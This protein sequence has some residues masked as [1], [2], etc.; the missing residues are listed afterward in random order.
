MK[1]YHNKITPIYKIFGLDDIHLFLENEF[2]HVKHKKKTYK[3]LPK[4]ITKF[5]K[6]NNLITI[7]LKLVFDDGS[8][9]FNRLTE[10]QFNF[11]FIKINLL[12]D[13]D[14]IKKSEEE[15]NLLLNKNLYVNKKKIINWQKKFEHINDLISQL[16]TEYLSNEENIF[17]SNF[18]NIE[19][20][21]KDKNSRFIQK[22]KNELKTFFDNLESSPL[23]N[24][25]RVSIIMDDDANLVVAGAGTGKTSTVMGKI[26]YLIKRKIVKPTEILA[27][28]YGKDAAAEMRERVSEKSGEKI[29]IKTF[30]SFGLHLMQNELNQKVKISDVAQY[31]KSLLS[32]IA[33]I[34]SELTKDENKRKLVINFIAKH[35]Y[36]AKYLEDFKSDA[37]YFKYL[38]KFEPETLEGV[39]VKSFEELLIADWLTLNGISYE[40]ERPYEHQTASRLRN[41]YRPD[42]YIKFEDTEDSK[43]IYLE[44]FGVNRE[45]KTAEHINSELYN[46]GIQWKRQIHKNHQTILIE[47]FSW[48]RQEGILLE[49]LKHKLESH[50]IFC[51]PNDPKIVQKL[52]EQRNVNQKLVALIKDFLNVFKE[53]Q[54]T[55]KELE[56]YSNTLSSNEK[57]RCNCFLELFFEVF[58][59]YTNYLKR[60]QEIDFADLIVFATNAIKLKKVKLNFKRIIVDE[61]QDISRGRFRMIKSIVEQSEDCRVMCVGDDWQSIYGFTGSDI[62]MTLEFENLIG[63]FTRT[64]LDQTFRFPDPILNVSS[65]FIQKNPFQLLKKIKA[66]PSKIKKTIEIFPLEQNQLKNFNYEEVFKIIDKDR[67]KNKTWDVLM[68]GRYNFT[69]PEVPKVI[70]EKYKKLNIKFMTIHKSKGLGADAVIVLDL[71][72]GRMG[73]PGY[74]E[75][76]PLMNM[77]IAGEKEF[78]HS[79]ERRVFYVAMTRAKKKLILC[80]SKYNSSEFIDELITGNYPEIDCSKLLDI[81]SFY[82]PSCNGGEIELKYPNRINGY[83]WRCSLHPYCKGKFKFCKICKNSPIN[84]SG[85][86]MN[87][88]CN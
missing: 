57:E 54:Y 59:V 86:C 19:K 53:G 76:D 64:D 9:I 68:L 2:L 61:Y 51:N 14:L 22:E 47:T 21:I 78:L 13:L 87:I 27:L 3:L 1:H 38:R 30:H 69:N 77:V 36:P 88:N 84:D 85:R 55:R 20:K 62:K 12:K 48:Q 60:R 43:G 72:G 81:Q 31:P 37:E 73:F 4:K 82:C 44:H 10:N 58:N 45:G 40:Y 11:L 28:A 56:E 32:L 34:L 35:R 26:S 75:S 42:F 33:Q 18:K 65:K 16:P 23:T 67:P 50:G 49:K 25:Q 17:L 39:R 79:E 29:E 46:K 8:F 63:Y 66:F 41:Q 5:I 74:I 52:Q 70:L 6:V 15:I 71:N 24:S 7:G 83:A 80:T